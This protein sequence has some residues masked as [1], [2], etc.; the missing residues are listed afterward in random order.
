MK[1]AH[2]VALFAALGVSSL[3]AC[4]QSGRDFSNGHGPGGAGGP[5]GGAISNPAEVFEG[6]LAITPADKDLDVSNGPVSV[7]YKVTLTTKSG[8]KSDVT[9]RVTFSEE[10]DAYGGALGKFAGA[11]FTADGNRVGRTMIT[12]RLD[13]IQGQTSLSLHAKRAIVVSGTDPSAPSKFAGAD[14]AANAPS[15]VYP[16]DGTLVP[17]NLNELEFQY[18]PGAGQSLFELS[19]DSPYLDLKVYFGCQPLAGGCAYTP[20]AAVWNLVASA[21]RDADPIPYRLRATDAGGGTIARSADRRIGFGRENITG[22]VYYWNAAA[23]QTKRYEF[24]V[25]GQQAETFLSPQT[26]GSIFCVGCHSISRDGRYIAVGLDIPGSSYKTLSVST[27]QQIFALPGGSFFSFS[28]DA[29]QLMTSNGATIVWRNTAN[30]S[31]IKDPLVPQGTMPDWSAD[32]KSLVYVKSRDPQ[33]GAPAVSKGG[34]EVITLSGNTWSAPT[35]LVPQSGSDNN[36]YPTYSPDSAWVLFN[37]SPS[38]ESSMGDSDGQ[39]NTPTGV[40]DGQIWMVPSAGGPARRLEA[41]SSGSSSGNS[42]ESWPKWIPV[43]QDYRGKK[44]MWFTFSSRRP[45]GLRLKD[46][47]RTQLWMAAFDPEKGLAGADPSLPA[48]RLPFQEIDSGNHIAQ[49]VTRVER[50][51]CGGPGACATGESCIEGRCVPALK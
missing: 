1:H 21:G 11:K 49:W 10:A 34:L 38:G 6:T 45:Y 23:G 3:V 27:R 51:P 31:P 39:N 28:P 12:A 7:D 41:S 16:N 18:V 50:Q 43:A 33:F 47:E 20:D 17:P 15:I 14:S 22:G 48:F 19:F 32:G 35:E 13:K 26:A 24:G 30:G 25:S 37:R 5:G 36:Y 9:D 4:G 42:Y 2:H 44:L 40:P 46:G 8:A 29:N